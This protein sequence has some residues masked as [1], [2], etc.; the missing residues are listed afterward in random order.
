FTA[1]LSSEKQGELLTAICQKIDQLAREH[2]AVRVRFQTSPLCW[3]GAPK[4]IP[5]DFDRHGYIAVPLATQIV[6]LGREFPS[7]LQHMRKGHAY[8]VKRGLKRF[9]VT[10]YDADSITD[11]IFARYRSLHAQAAGRV[12]RPLQ[13]FALMQQW[14]CEGKAVLLGAA[15]DGVE[16]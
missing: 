6:A 13:T 12:T 8:D 2:N 10:C 5:A 14:I 4:S 11:D 15:Q 1:Q 9:S 7:L 16:V 3:L